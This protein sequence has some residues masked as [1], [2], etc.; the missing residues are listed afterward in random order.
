MPGLRSSISG[1]SRPTRLVSRPSRLLQRVLRGLRAPLA[2]PCSAD[3]A[4]GAR[5]R[6]LPARSHRALQ[7]RE[8]RR[9]RHRSSFCAAAR[10]ELRIASCWATPARAR[11]P[12]TCRRSCRARCRRCCSAS[13]TAS[14]ARTGRLARRRDRERER[15]EMRD[16]L[17]LG[18]NADHDRQRAD[19]ERA[20]A[21][22]AHL[23][24]R[25]VACSPLMTPT[26]MSC[27]I[28]EAAAST[29]PATTATIVANATAATNASKKLPSSESGPPPTNCASSGAAMLPPRSIARDRRGADV[30]SPRRCRGTASARRSR[31]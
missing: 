11:R 19:D 31:R 24:L 14:A 8:A 13:S 1:A 21:R 7:L 30:A 3:S 4:F 2:H 25:A 12:R 17:A 18:E 5:R 6:R 28:A 26:Q 10:L 20:D 23:L 29:R 15:D 9:R 27:D 22:G 16:V